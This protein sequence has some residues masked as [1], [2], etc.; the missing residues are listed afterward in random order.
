MRIAFSLV[1]AA[2]LSTGAAACAAG[3]GQDPLT[4]QSQQDGTTSCVA[5]TA[6]GPQAWNAPVGSAEEMFTNTSAAPLTIGSVSLLDP[7]NLV[8]HGSVLYR[9]AHA[10]HALPPSWSWVREGQAVP[11]AD[12]RARQRVPG[13]VMPPAGR[14]VELNGRI[15]SKVDRW[16]IALDI[17]AASPAGGWARGEVVHYTAASRSYTLVARNGMAIG[18]SRRPVQPSCDASMRAMAAAAGSGS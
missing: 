14:P 3:S 17:S 5:S 4:L 12:W 1:I 18:T 13:A 11:P 15:N 2:A 10:A 9:M 8:L 7:H 6:S 16:Q